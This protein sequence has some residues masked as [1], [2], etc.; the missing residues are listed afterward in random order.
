M[1]RVKIGLAMCLWGL[2]AQG[3]VVS[4]VSARPFD[5]GASDVP[6]GYQPDNGPD[7]WGELSPA[8]RQCSEG[9]QQ[10]P[11]DITEYRSELLP[12]LSFQ[13]RSSS[14]H[15]INDGLVIRVLYEPGSYLRVGSNRYELLQVDFHTPGEHTRNGIAADME[16][17]LVHRD[18]RGNYAMVAIPVVAGRRHNSLL[19]RIWQ[20]LPTQAGQEYENA[21]TGIKPVFLLPP[22]KDYYLYE[23]SLSNPPCT[24]G[25]TWFVMRHAIE[26]PGQYI[27][28]FRQVLGH[29]SRPTQPLNGRQILA[30]P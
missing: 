24:E 26:V 3:L 11:V 10:S 30:G 29:N 1:M 6:W 2:A 16:I 13:Y 14:L 4:E 20:D 18:G 19:S 7:R 25:V 8:Y 28:R 12:H 27:E 15:M 22:N 21:Y 5:G 9:R 17:H 23:G